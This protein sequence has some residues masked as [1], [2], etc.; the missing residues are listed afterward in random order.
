MSLI[1]DLPLRFAEQNTR[2]KGMVD[3]LCSDTRTAK[4]EVV[5]LL[6]MI[7]EKDKEEAKNKT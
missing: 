6:A 3:N 4:D 2:L 7:V 1:V 5:E